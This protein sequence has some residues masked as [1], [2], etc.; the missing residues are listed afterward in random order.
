MGRQKY[1]KRAM[2]LFEKTPIVT[3]RD[4]RMV[5]NA[6]GLKKTYS[7]LFIH[8]LI[9][10]GKIR[11]IT[12]GFYTIHEDPEVAVFCF[13]PAYIGLQDSLSIHNLW[14]QEGNV[15]IITSRKVR[16]GLREMLGSKVVI[17][18]IDKK[19]FFGNET[20]KYGDFYLPVSDI[21]KTFI[22]FVHFREPLDGEVVSEIKK[23]LSLSKLGK[24]LKKYPIR[25]RKKAAN[26][27]LP[28][29]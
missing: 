11:Q 18:R 24:Y 19:Y 15:V 29:K 17:R 9:K 5:I 21:E 27:L 13:R 25:T 22:D 16:N 8:N 2:E 1:I 14:S 20:L 12:K 23:R 3:S 28:R 10:E 4:I 7:R 6:S 26:L